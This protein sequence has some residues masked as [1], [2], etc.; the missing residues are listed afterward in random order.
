MERLCPVCSNSLKNIVISD[1]NA[2]DKEYNVYHCNACDIGVTGP[3]PSDLEIEKFYDSG[4]YRT[5]K[6]KR[7]HYL[8]ERLVHFFTIRKGKEIKKYVKR[9]RILDIGCGRGLFLYIMKIDGWDVTGTEINGESAGYAKELYGVTVLVGDIDKCSFAEK[10]FDVIHVCHVLEHTTNPAELIIQ[11]QELLK[12][13]GILAITI[14]NFSSLQARYGKNAWFHLD[15]PYHLYH[16]SERGLKRLIEKNG[17]EILKI[18]HFDFEQN[19]FGWLQTLLNRRGIKRNLLYNS[20]KKPELRGFISEVTLFKDI[21]YTFI[22]L[23]FFI[24][25]A[26]LLSIFEA[27]ILK[28]GGT[29]KVIC[30]KK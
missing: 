28:A 1:V 8:I 30:R 18:N 25:L 29:I 16:F 15:I 2:L 13:S 14:P 23:P 11:C 24:P 19:P 26:L 7:F 21:L 20:L 3:F 9:G 12:K 27:Y 17:F 6:G 22:L 4:H 10:S 5:K